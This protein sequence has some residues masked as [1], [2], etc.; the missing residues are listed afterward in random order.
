MQ[1]LNKDRLYLSSGPQAGQHV[2]A[3]TVLEESVLNA[4]SIPLLLEIGVL[5]PFEGDA[6]ALVGSQEPVVTSPPDETF[7][8]PGLAYE[9]GAQTAP[10]EP[11]ASAGEMPRVGRKKRK[12]DFTEE[13]A[14]HGTDDSSSA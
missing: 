10:A 3:G 8:V 2:E 7:L 11:D 4:E 13:V 14:N 5:V 1:Y 12:D 6:A 9:P